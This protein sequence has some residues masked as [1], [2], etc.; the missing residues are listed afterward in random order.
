MNGRAR[1]SRRNK[2]HA[3]THRTTGVLGAEAAVLLAVAALW[4]AN[5]GGIGYLLV[6]L[7][8]MAMS[9]QSGASI[10]W[11]SPVSAPRSSPARDGARHLV[12]RMA[13]RADRIAATPSRTAGRCRHDL[14][15]RRRRRGGI[16]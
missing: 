1:R 6:G 10:G 3:W 7:L 8:G 11:A 4:L 12:R 15:P 2:D 16:V 5:P 13:A 9:A 14:Y